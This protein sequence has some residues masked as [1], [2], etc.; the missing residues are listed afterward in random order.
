MINHGHWWDVAF[1]KELYQVYLS[2]ALRSFA[3]SLIGLFVPLYV[4][5]ELGYTLKET[6]VYFVFYSLLFAVFTP[7]AAA[8]S[9]KFGAKHSILLSV[10]FHLVYI[11]LLY[12]AQRFLV[13]LWLMALF[14]SLAMAFYWFGMNVIIYHA[15]DHK[16]RG[17]EVGKRAGLSILATMIGPLLGGIMITKTGFGALFIFAAAVLFSSAII[18]FISPEQKQDFHFSFKSVMNK[19]HWRDS[20]FF[21]S[22]G[23]W[24]SVEG[25]VWP[26]FIF[27]ILGS[28]IYLGM[29]GSVLAAVSSILVF[30]VGK[31]S[32]HV[33]KR[34]IIKL[35]VPFESLSWI[36][37]L[38]VATV[39]QV[40][41]IT[42]FGAIVFGIWQSPLR[43]LELDKAK[44]NPAGYFVSREI[45]ICIGRAVP[46][47]LILLTDRLSDGFALQAILS[48]AFLLF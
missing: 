35:I 44:E 12:A 37:R 34:K 7:M 47:V 46:L 19:K 26:L 33:R 28:Y 43:A 38:L 30:L 41:A 9:A 32:D 4:H 40:F 16:H 8:F 24:V 3:I 18:L 6:L 39:N 25:I 13:S 31:Y 10:P 17:E 1:K 2:S 20:L 45:F 23:S 48:F 42:I 15:T 21:V 29:V 5:V 11:S 27:S 22:Q 14:V 36:V